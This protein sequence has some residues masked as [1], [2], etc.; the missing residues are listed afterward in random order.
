MSYV[1]Y[2]KNMKETFF[3]QSPGNSIIER[4]KGM[5]SYNYFDK[6]KTQFCMSLKEGLKCKYGDKCNYAHSISEL[7]V[8]MCNYPYT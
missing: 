3:L 2:T 7:R 5:N 4:E 8:K 6:T 1:G